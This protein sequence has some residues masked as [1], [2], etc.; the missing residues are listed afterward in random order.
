MI[1]TLPSLSCVENNPLWESMLSQI[2]RSTTHCLITG[3]PEESQIL[4]NSL[5][6]HPELSPIKT[7]FL[8]DITLLPLNAQQRLAKASENNRFMMTSEYEIAIALKKRMLDESLYDVLKNLVIHIVPHA[9]LK[10]HAFT[11]TVLINAS[12]LE[13]HISLKDLLGE[14]ENRYIEEA[15]LKANGVVSVAATLLGLRRTTLIEKIKKINHKKPQ[16]S[17]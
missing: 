9:Q 2:A 1:I 14:I 10:S 12:R 11:E 4:I 7:H 17:F 6:T 13:N 5:M 8:R 15:L 16:A 3:I